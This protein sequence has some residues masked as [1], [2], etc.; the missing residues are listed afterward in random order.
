MLFIVN[1]AGFMNSALIW[2]IGPVNHIFAAFKE[3]EN[4]SSQEMQRPALANRSTTTKG[5]TTPVSPPWRSIVR[6]FAKKT[7]T[8]A[9]N[10]RR[11]AGR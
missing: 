6:S 2:F 11:D 1:L 9:P 7:I 10:D 3:K 5:G 8:Q 4:Q